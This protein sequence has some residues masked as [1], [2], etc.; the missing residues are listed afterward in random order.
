[1]N[2][3]NS[4]LCPLR[5][6]HSH[7]VGFCFFFTRGRISHS[8]SPSPPAPSLPSSMR[9]ASGS[10][11]HRRRRA[12]LPLPF[13][14]AASRRFHGDVL[15]MNRRTGPPGGNATRRSPS[16]GGKSWS[17]G[18]EAARS[19]GRQVGC[20]GEGAPRRLRLPG[21]AP[22]RE[23]CKARAAARRGGRGLQPA[24]AAALGVPRRDL[25]ALPSARSHAPTPTATPARP[26]LQPEAFSLNPVARSV[27]PK[28]APA[29][30]F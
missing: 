15:L 21:P 16:S 9:T 13:P 29:A 1:M 19:A 22:A 17:L 20:G 10:S 8:G 18:E 2:D 24:P 11:T 14:P 27:R 3:V 7:P 5:A 28:W 30:S 25:W 26:S 4:K 6:V 23:P 12:R